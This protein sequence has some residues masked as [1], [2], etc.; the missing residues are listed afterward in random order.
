MVRPATA[1]IAFGLVAVCMCAKAMSVWFTD[2]RTLPFSAATV[3]VENE[4]GAEINRVV[5]LVNTK[6][7]TS[8]T[9]IIVLTAVVADEKAESQLTGSLRIAN[10][11]RVMERLSPLSQAVYDAVYTDDQY[12]KHWSAAHH[13]A[14][15]PV[16][17]VEID[18]AC[19]PK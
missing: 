8:G 17:S 15:A 13:R 5:E 1:S 12:Q 16:N 9:P 10:V 7:A 6:C 2:V 14:K 19:H 4:N 3:E 18:L 11:K